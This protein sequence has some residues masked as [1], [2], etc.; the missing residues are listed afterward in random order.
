MNKGEL[1]ERVAKEAKITKVEASRAIDAVFTTIRKTLKRG[2]KTSLVGFGTFS[3]TRR[4][5]RTGRN[6]QTGEPLRIPARRVV[7]FSSGKA[8]KETIR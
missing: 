2:E 1:I 3:V 5:A 6:P 7:R 8:L 4:K